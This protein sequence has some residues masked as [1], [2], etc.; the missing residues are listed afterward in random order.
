MPARIRY[1]RNTRCA[2]VGEA[3]VFLDVIM[4]FFVRAWRW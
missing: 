2:C 3:S 1:Q 4:C